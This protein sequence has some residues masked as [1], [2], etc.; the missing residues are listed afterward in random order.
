MAKSGEE[1]VIRTVCGIVDGLKCGINA[2]V[3]D[4]VLVKVSPADFPDPRFRHVCSRALC[5]PQLVYHPDRLKHPLKRVGERG[6]GKWQRITWDEAL[7]TIAS[8]LTEIREKYGPESLAWIIE[9]IA[10]LRLCCALEATMINP[11]GFGDAAGPCG[12]ELSFGTHYGSLYTMDIEKPGMCVLWGAN[13]CETR[14]YYWRRI[15]DAKEG[16]ARLVAIDPRFTSSASKADEYISIRPGTDVALILGMMNVIFER[17]LQDEPFITEHTVGPFL[18]RSDNGLFLRE[19]D[20]VSGGSD[21]HMVWDTKAS[22]HAIYDEKDVTPALSGSYEVAGIQCQPAFQLLADLAKQYPLEKAAGITEVPAQTIERLAM[23][24]VTRRPIAAYTSMGMQRTFHG[25]VSYRAVNA[26]AAVTGS[27]NLEGYSEGY[28]RFL[29]NGGTILYGESFPRPLSLLQ[30]YEAITKGEPYPIKS[31]WIAGHNFMNQN[32]DNNRIIKELVPNLEFIVVADMFMTNSA[33]YADIVLPTC[34]FYE[35][36]DLQTPLDL[37]SPYMQLQPKVI[38]PLHDSKPDRDIVNELGLKLGLGEDFVLSAEEY[39]RR[40][41]TSGHP[42]MEGITLEK[43]KQGPVEVGPY[44]VTGFRNPSGRIEFYSERMKEFGQELPL[45]LEPIESVRR[46]AASKYPLSY[47]SPHT[48]YGNHSLMANVAWLR[49]LDPEPVLEMNPVDAGD[50]GI[51]DGDMVEAFN[52][53]GSVKL[54]ARVHQ[55]VRPGAVSIY[56]GW[57]REHFAEGTFQALTHA[58]INPAQSAV[59]EPNSAML[60]VL[61]EVRKA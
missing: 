59:F 61:C 55:G 27:I 24:H 58:T 29:F 32:P 57:W 5:S 52:N 46:P 49:E 9:V 54:R 30:A 13:Q 15:R 6:E 10:Y 31:L 1:Q 3:R 19:S 51:E 47:L 28:R 33:R 44:N 16:G 35:H 17:G 53:R 2:H 36:L 39:V 60:D 4:G 40:V 26:L 8:R 18:V 11:I 25:D 23:D 42:S 45:Y 41:V 48:K 14:P 38:E 37:F 43:L 21:R 12:D 7:D 22:K 20:V 34:S 56:E 50:R